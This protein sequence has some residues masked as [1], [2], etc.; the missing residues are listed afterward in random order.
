MGGVINGGFMVYEK[1]ICDYLSPDVNAD[2]EHG[3]LEDL[4]KQGKILVYNHTGEWA[5][6]DNVR[7]MNYLNK[8]W[9]EGKAFWKLWKK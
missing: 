1:E 5:C 9:L 6:M 8:L 7:D 4:A 2:F 3:P